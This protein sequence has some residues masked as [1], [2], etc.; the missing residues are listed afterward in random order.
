MIA[1]QSY[2][3]MRVQNQHE[4]FPQRHGKIKIYDG[5]FAHST[6]F[7]FMNFY[8]YIQ[9]EWIQKPRVRVTD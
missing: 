7:V 1:T 3:G 8:L 2:L 5:I 4:F 9:A 6:T